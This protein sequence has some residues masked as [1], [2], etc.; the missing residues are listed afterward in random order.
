MGLEAVDL[1]VD[2][3]RCP[4]HRSILTG[5]R[6]ARRSTAKGRFVS[7]RANRC[8]SESVRFHTLGVKV[9]WSWGT[10]FKMYVFGHF[11]RNNVRYRTLRIGALP[12]IERV[13]HVRGCH[14]GRTRR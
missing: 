1:F 3:S 11:S 7:A 2:R 4:E 12:N 13:D 5:A 9:S 14:S 10:Q 8:H 6:Q